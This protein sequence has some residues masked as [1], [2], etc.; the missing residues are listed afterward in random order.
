MTFPD[1]QF[2]VMLLDPAWWYFGCPNKM[3]AAGK[4]YPLMKTEDIKA[5]P[6]AQHL[7]PRGVVFLWTTGPQLQIAMDCLAAW[8]L[9]YR[10]VGFVW[11]KTRL[12]G[13]PLGAMGVRPSIIKQN[14]T[15]F[16]LCGSR[17]PKG[18]PMPIADESI[19]QTVLAPRGAHSQKPEAVQERIE[20]LYP[21]ARRLE[22]FARRQRPGWTCIG[23][24]CPP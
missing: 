11:V 3:G 15:E 13:R 21:Q 20:L 22:V 24:Q 9:A 6:V 12:D 5:L 2:E 16:V 17:V 19:V 1:Q 8:G 18:R 14:L 7:A 4:H 10:G 23:D